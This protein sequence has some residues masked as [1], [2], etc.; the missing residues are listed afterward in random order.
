M[1]IR[2]GVR[3]LPV[4]VSVAVTLGAVFL[5]SP[6]PVVAQS[7]WVLWQKIE[8]TDA[9]DVQTGWAIEAAYET[10]RECDIAQDKDWKSTAE[11]VQRSFGPD[12]VIAVPHSV[13]LMGTGSGGKGITM[14][15]LLCVPGTIDPRGAK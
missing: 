4:V 11:I 1:N 9:V 6:A 13:T 2:R 8:T 3:R 15:R 14:I 5:A 7:A 12:R 10:K